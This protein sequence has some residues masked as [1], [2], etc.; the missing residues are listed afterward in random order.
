MAATR[1]SSK[2]A[3]ITCEQRRDEIIGVLAT[4][5]V[6][7]IQAGQP[8]GEKLSESS[9]TGLELPRETRLSVPAG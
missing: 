7:L 4:G 8:P 6:W 1:T 9:E 5:L 3:E 2:L